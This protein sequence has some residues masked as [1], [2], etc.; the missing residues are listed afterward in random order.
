MLATR[1]SREGIM[2]IAITER[3]REM[4]RRKPRP[5]GRCHHCEKKLKKEGRLYCNK[6]CH[7]RDMV[8]NGVVTGRPAKDPEDKAVN[9]TVT[10]TPGLAKRAARIGGSKDGRDKA[11]IRAGIRKILEK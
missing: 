7:F 3:G 4:S 10:L 6:H 9:V 2:T 5:N 8:A 1:G 11:A